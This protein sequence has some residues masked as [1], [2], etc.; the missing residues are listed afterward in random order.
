MAPSPALWSLRARWV[1]PVAAPPL[2]N[3]SVTVEGERIAAVGAAGARKPGVDLGD[4]AVLPGLVNAHTHLDLSGFRQP[5]PFAGDFTAWLGAVVAHRRGRPPEQVAADVRAGLAQSLAR[6]VTLLGDISAQG[7]SW[8]ALAGAPIRSVVFYELL[9]LPGDRAGRAWADALAWVRDH[10]AT[11]TCRPGLSPHAPYSVRASLFRACA[12]LAG[13]RGLPVATHLAET[14]AEAELLARH[15]GPF[16]DFLRGLG[17][18]E[19][20]GLV[21]DAAAVLRQSAAVPRL[22]LAHGNYLDPAALLPPGATVVYCPR[23]HAHF[24]HPPHPFRALLARGARVALG[25]DSLASNPD[26]DVLAEARFLHRRDPDFPGDQLL[27]MATLAGAEALGRAAEAG[28]LEPGKSADL[29]VV[30]LGPEAAAGAD[31]YRRLLAG[32]EPVRRV[33]FRGRWVT[34]GE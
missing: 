5:V 8:P 15:A 14:A 28:S 9:G 25:T 30:P 34:G 19:P 20:A 4:A 24:G 32:A 17:A 12:A 26:L 7:S 18:W 13:A 23:T 1:F 6:G 27:R 22:L 29:A 10:P 11:D 21:P 31:P 3:G 16:A 33:L 2:E